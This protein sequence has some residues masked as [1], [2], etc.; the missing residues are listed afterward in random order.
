MP[1]SSEF[2]T[3]NSNAYDRL[4]RENQ[5]LR[6]ELLH[7]RQ[8]IQALNRLRHSLKV[9]SPRADIFSLLNSILEIALKAVD[10]ENGSLQLLDEE[11]GELVFAEVQGPSREKLTGYRL[12]PGAG[13]AG[14]VAQNRSPR[15]VTDVSQEPRFSPQVD[16]TLGFQTDSLICAPL[17][18]GER[19]LGVIEAVNTRSGASFRAEDLDILLLVAQLAALALSRADGQGE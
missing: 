16:Q 7:L 6:E 9:G 10:S 4:K 11:T 17:L 8:T 18:D 1:A 15:L 14:W 5:A 13:I 2:S 12:P 19:T 3:R